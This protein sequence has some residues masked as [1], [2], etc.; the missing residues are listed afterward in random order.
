VPGVSN[1]VRELAQPCSTSIAVDPAPLSGD[2]GPTRGEVS[3]KPRWPPS[4]Y[5]HLT[6]SGHEL[7]HVTHAV[8]SD[9]ASVNPM[10]AA[11][12]A[13]RLMTLLTTPRLLPEASNRA[14]NVESMMRV[15]ATG[16]HD[17]I[18]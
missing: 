2:R 5:V 12:R 3:V 7:P 18:A 14:L 15:K 16:A 11:N 8:K 6:E 17:A 4:A 1:H 9:T 13:R 10:S